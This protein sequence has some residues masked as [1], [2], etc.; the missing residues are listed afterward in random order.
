[1]NRFIK[2]D[3]GNAIGTGYHPNSCTNDRTL[4]PSPRDRSNRDKEKRPVWT[5]VDRIE[6]R[7]WPG[8]LCDGPSADYVALVADG[9]PTCRNHGAQYKRRETAM[10][11]TIREWESG[12][13]LAEAEVGPSLAKFEGNWYFDP[14]AVQSDRLK[15]TERTYTCP[16]KGTCNWVD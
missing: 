5:G 12:T 16:V 3:A 6:R 11:I 8:P 14:S 9:F 13:S 2:D 1:L 7:L 4:S 15:V 10:S